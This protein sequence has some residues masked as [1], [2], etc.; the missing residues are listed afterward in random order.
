MSALDDVR[1][2]PA[3]D[4]DEWLAH[5]VILFFNESQQIYLKIKKKCTKDTCP[6]MMAGKKFEYMWHDASNPLYSQ[7]PVSLSAP[8]Y[9]DCLLLWI[10]TYLDEEKVFPKYKGNPFPEDFKPSIV[11]NVVRRL[12]RI[13]AHVYRHHIDE[14]SAMK[15]D[16]QYLEDS[17]KHFFRFAHHN[18]FIPDSELDALADIIAMFY[19]RK[20]GRPNSSKE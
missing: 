6:K 11:A 8:E 20:N 3:E 18:Q 12:F 19:D 4:P 13:Y 17:F 5:H 10:Q 9:I 1:C 16:K 2:P 15:D 7:R 14:I